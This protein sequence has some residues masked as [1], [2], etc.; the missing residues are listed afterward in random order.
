MATFPVS[1]TTTLQIMN[2][3]K[4]IGMV[5]LAVKPSPITLHPTLVARATIVYGMKVG[6]SYRQ[7]TC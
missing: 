4:T 6:M 5:S 2:P 7:L 1:V 3:K